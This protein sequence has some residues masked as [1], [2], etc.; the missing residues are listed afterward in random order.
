MSTIGFIGSGNIGTTVARLAVAAG[1]QVVMSNRRGADTLAGLVSDLGPGARATTPEEAARAG[2]IVIVSIPLAAYRT[3][4]VEPLRGKVLIDTNNYYPLRDGHMAELDAET[5]TTSELL[6]AH[7]PE[8]HVVKGLNSIYFAHL[9]N[10]ARPNGHPERSPLT[11][12]GDSD[13]A[14]KAVADFFDTIG[15]DTLDLGPLAE[16]WRTQRDTT[17]Y[18]E[19]YFGEGRSLA[20][21]G[22]GADL[23]PG[24]PTTADALRRA[25]AAA[26]RYR[27]M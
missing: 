17:A 8:S 23:G 16:G 15:Y 2:D 1:H 3:V 4:P 10:L 21:M 20:A 24:A 25:L 11:M 12:A 6:Q 19:P 18:C 5:T 22:Q 27:D 13:D 7:V 26:K 9:A 14:K